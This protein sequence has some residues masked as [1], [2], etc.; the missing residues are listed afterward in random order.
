[1]ILKFTGGEGRVKISAGAKSRLDTLT[2]VYGS[3]TAVIEAGIEI[4]ANTQYNPNLSAGTKQ[5]L[6][7][8]TRRFKGSEAAVIELAI[9]H[10]LQSA[11]STY[12]DQPARDPQITVM[13]QIT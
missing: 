9:Q 5:R 12:Q 10:L 2:K 13:Q 7:I 6:K 8:L 3:D 4:L 1:M 11:L